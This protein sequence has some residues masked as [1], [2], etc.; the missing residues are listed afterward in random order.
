MSS[1]RAGGY[2]F[3]GAMIGLWAYLMGI[4][5][6]R[7][8]KKIQY[9]PTSKAISVAPGLAEVAGTAGV[10]AEPVAAP[11]TGQACAYFL[12]RTYTW[13]GSGKNRS[14]NLYGQTESPQPIYVE[15]DTGRVMLRPDPAAGKKQG[16]LD[17]IIPKGQIGYFIDVDVK[18]TWSG[19]GLLG[20][21]S[22]EPGMKEFLQAHYPKLLDYHDRV[23][24]E[25]TYIKEKDPIYVLGPARVADGP[26][27]AAQM[28]I[29]NDRNV[30]CVADGSEKN[31]LADVSKHIYLMLL[32][33]PLL[34]GA[35]LS[36][37]ILYYAGAGGM[38]MVSLVE[39]VV[40]AM[41]AYLG[42]ITLLEMYN[43]LVVLKN[44]VERA[45]ANTDALLQ[46]RA[47][48]LPQLEKVVSGYAKYEKSLNG[49]MAQLR[50]GAVGES[51]KTVIGIAEAY[52]KLKANE[53]FLSFQAQLEKTE[54]WIAASRQFI[55]D[56]VM[57]YNTQVS[58]FPY[59]LF[60][61]LMGLRPMEYTAQQSSA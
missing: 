22:F 31:A 6:Y 25:E 11:Y 18:K 61:P 12:T 47:D 41:Y 2:L 59:L 49:R 15:D 44:N 34:F 10:V 50:A 13:S 23:D 46:R 51:G 28:L 57:L 37:L 4:G 42:A 16:I 53:N 56:S 5:H 24:V 26:D 7:L 33:G 19:K 43:G 36:A 21:G 32:G 58:S 17:S 38:W 29:Q 54:E 52:P 8:R 60:A 39:W 45:R 9:T 40:G 55:N 20:T 1:D 30:F 3:V 48:L 35:C 14:R 27:G